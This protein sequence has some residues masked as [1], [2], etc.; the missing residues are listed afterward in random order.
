LRVKGISPLP[1]IGPKVAGRG[2]WFR[3]AIRLWLAAPVGAQSAAPA[4]WKARL[5]VQVGR[6][7]AGHV[8]PVSGR[9]GLTS[10]AP[11]CG[12][13]RSTEIPSKSTGN[14][15]LSHLPALGQMYLA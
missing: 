6:T 10:R 13:P 1:W 12:V 7:A 11:Q 15:S 14:P 4:G 3:K 5:A 8:E 2:I 9:A